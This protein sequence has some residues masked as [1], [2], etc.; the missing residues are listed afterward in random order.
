MSSKILVGCPTSF[1]KEYALQQYANSIKKLTYKNHDVLLVDNSEDNVY[2]EKIKSLGIPVI[3]GP[4]FESA[5]DR[6]IA[7][8]NILRQKVLDEGYDY[9]LSLEQDVL[10]PE[11]FIESLLKHN[12]EV[13]TGVYFADNIIPGKPLPELIPLVYILENPETLSMRPLNQNELWEFPGLMEVISA[14]LGCV[15]I[16]KNVLK[17]IK[18]RYDLNTFDD[19]WFFLD[20]YNKKIKVY[21]DTSLNCRHLIHNRP[22]P[23]NKIQK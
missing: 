16:H 21:A 4:W 7:S 14:G 15:L 8:R 17:D 12:K 1:H 9:F 23:W 2:F 20:L 11:N 10:P 6:I 13:I 19:R 5:R 3:K 22:Y 18:F